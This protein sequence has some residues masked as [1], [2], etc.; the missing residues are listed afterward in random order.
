MLERQLNLLNEYTK[1]N[2]NILT[3]FKRFFNGTLEFQKESINQ[4]GFWELR[5]KL[6][7]KML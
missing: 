1:Y 5:E 6:F 4:N 3:K 7:T 2:Q